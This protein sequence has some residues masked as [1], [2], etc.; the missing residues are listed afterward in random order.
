[1]VDERHTTPERIWLLLGEGENGGH[2]WCDDPDPTGAGEIEA[3]EYV[4]VDVARKVA[5]G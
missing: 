1:M 3:V 5:D 2:L 4:R